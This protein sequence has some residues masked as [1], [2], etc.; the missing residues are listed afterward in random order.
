MEGAGS[1]PAS[2]VTPHWLPHAL[3][4]PFIL[5][6]NMPKGPK[7]AFPGSLLPTLMWMVA[8]DR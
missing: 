7:E 3:H 4:T 1:I 5:Q 2:E 6:A 8:L